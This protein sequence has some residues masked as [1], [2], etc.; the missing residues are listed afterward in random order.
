M[1]DALLFQLISILFLFILFQFFLKQIK[2][3][4][5]AIEHFSLIQLNLKFDLEKIVI[6]RIGNSRRSLL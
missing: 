3:G 5:R 2:L 6:M 1:V 4:V